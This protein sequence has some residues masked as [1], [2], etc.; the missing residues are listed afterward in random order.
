MLIDVLVSDLDN[1]MEYTS[2]KLAGDTKLGGELLMC[3]ESRTALQRDL[4]RLKERADW[5]L[6]NKSKSCIWDGVTQ[7]NSTGWG[8]LSR[9]Q[10]RG[11]GSGRPSGQQ[12]EH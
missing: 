11:K 4:D 10:L 9:K 12:V 1:G 5:N 8:Q 2:S 3:W 6:F 7:C